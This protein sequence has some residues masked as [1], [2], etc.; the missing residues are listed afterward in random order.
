MEERKLIL[1]NEF[2]R[3]EKLL[4]LKE[5]NLSDRKGYDENFLGT[6]NFSIRLP[7]LEDF[8]FGSIAKNQQPGSNGNNY[9]DYTHF[10]VMHNKKYK[11]PYF[12]AVN[13]DGDLNYLAMDHDER[14]GDNWDQDYRLKI[15]TDFYQFDDEDYYKSGLQK[16]HMVR[17]F[18]P[19]WGNTEEIQKIAIG[20]TFF[21]QILAL[22]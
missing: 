17:Y 11:L 4:Y 1:I 5:E 15:G 21:I 20:D 2:N 14:N 10:S 18:D 12:T 3:N 6:K 22:R 8:K 19:S 13:N 9:L 16:G 7:V